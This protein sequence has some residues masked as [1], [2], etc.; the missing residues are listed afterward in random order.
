MF[1]VIKKSLYEI[2]DCLN[3]GTH[4]IRRLQIMHNNQK[5]MI[6]INDAEMQFSI[7]FF[8]LFMWGQF[9]SLFWSPCST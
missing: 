7:F 1:L 2:T 3:Y 4:I 6:K 9:F 5:E 8:V